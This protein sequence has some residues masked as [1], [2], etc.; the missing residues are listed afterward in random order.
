MSMKKITALFLV[1]FLCFFTGACSDK[2]NNVTSE[3]ET[4]SQ[5]IEESSGEEVSET[6]SVLPSED[7][8]ASNKPVSSVNSK[9]GSS[10][11]GAGISL[12]AFASVK[13]K[14]VELFTTDSAATDQ[15]KKAIEDFKNLYG[16]TLKMTTADWANYENLLNARIMANN[17]P[18]VAIVRNADRY[19]FPLKGVLQDVSGKINF[20]SPLWKDVSAL[21]SGLAIKGKQYQISTGSFVPYCVWYNKSLMLDNGIIDTPDKLYDKGA[22]TVSAMR[23]LAK[24]LTVRSGEATTQFGLGADYSILGGCLM[25]AR[26]SEVVTRSDKAFSNNINDTKVADAMNTLYD[27][28][29]VDKSMTP[30]DQQINNFAKSRSAMLIEGTWLTQQKAIYTLKQKG[31]IAMVPFP[32]W[33]GADESHLMEVY[34]LGIP[35]GA[36]NMD[37]GLAYINYHRYATVDK[38][39]IE[40]ERSTQKTKYAMTDKELDYITNARAKGVTPS[41][42]GLPGDSPLNT[43]IFMHTAT[44]NSWAV[45]IEQYSPDV[46]KSI[47]ELNDLMK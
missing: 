6:E 27:M 12:P 20:D 32:K 21:N 41:W 1:V 4:S 16:A 26:G 25:T 13:G 36:K 45:T 28:Y 15:S 9:G 33:D 43:L 2:K 31:T 8:A 34:A 5:M 11:E 35:K 30:A 18:D 19:T 24:D 44:G 42:Y 37:Y 3:S 7:G 47:K 10:S 17:A 23:K 29:I 14:T 38:S 22:W 46:N 39:Q 40:K